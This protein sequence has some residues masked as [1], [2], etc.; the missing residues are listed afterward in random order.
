[1]KKR[2]FA[3]CGLFATFFVFTAFITTGCVS[4]GSFKNLERR[5]TDNSTDIGDVSA[6][7][8]QVAIVADQ[9]ASAL[10]DLQTRKEAKAAFTAI[11]ARIHKNEGRI[12]RNRETI[13]S[14]AYEQNRVNE[15]LGTVPISISFPVGG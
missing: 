5:V 2:M 14:A 15:A 13:S 12:F 1:M 4:R 10:E 7:I 3:L 9:T 6:K 11:K 8:G